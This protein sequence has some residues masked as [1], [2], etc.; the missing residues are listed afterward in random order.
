MHCIYPASVLSHS[1]DG[2]AFLTESQL[3]SLSSELLPAENMLSSSIAINP[4]KAQTTAA[5]NGEAQDALPPCSHYTIMLRRAML[6]GEPQV[7]SAAYERLQ[8]FLFQKDFFPPIFISTK[9]GCQVFCI[10]HSILCAH[11]GLF[12]FQSEFNL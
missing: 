3:P 12:N 8:D 4:D 11:L 7:T 2:V 10:I 1:H 9:Q 6:E 5:Q